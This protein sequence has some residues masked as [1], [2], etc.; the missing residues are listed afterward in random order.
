VLG[1]WDAVA[2]G[3]QK[4]SITDQLLQRI[5]KLVGMWAEEERMKG[6]SLL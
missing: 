1:V 5:K 3:L 6:K 2:G 4:E